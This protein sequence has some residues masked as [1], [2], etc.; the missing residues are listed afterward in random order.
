MRRRLNFKIIASVTFIILLAGA[1]LFFTLRSS[2]APSETSTNNPGRSGETIEITQARILAYWMGFDD[3]RDENNNWWTDAYYEHLNIRLTNLFTAPMWGTDFDMM[4]NLAFATGNLPDVMPLYTSLAVRAIEGGLV[5][6]LTDI[7][8][9]YAS[10]QVKE[11]FAQDPRALQAWTFDGRLMGLPQPA[12]SGDFVYFWV[13]AELL[14]QLNDGV[15]PRNFD[16]FNAL[17]RR[18]RDYTGGHAIAMD[19]NLQVMEFLMP[20]FGATSLWIEQDGALVWGR[21]QPEMQRL[22]QQ[23]A[24][25]YNEGILAVDFAAKNQEDIAYDFANRHAGLMADGSQ[26]PNGSAGRSFIM[27]HPHDDLVAIPLM[28]YDG[29]PVRIISDAGYNNALMI[30]VRAQNPEAIMHMFNLTTAIIN[31]GEYRPAWVTNHEWETSPA[32][33]M[34][35]WNALATGTGYVAD[36]QHSAAL[37]AVEAMQRGIGANE[38]YHAREFRTLGAYERINNWLQ[39][40]TAHDAW[41]ANWAMWNMTLGS[42]SLFTTGDKRAA[43]YIVPSPRWGVETLSEAT[44]NATLAMRFVEFA[45]IAIVENDVD[46]QFNHWLNFFYAN[47]GHDINREVNEWWEM[48]R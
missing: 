26:L 42:R 7:F 23:M 30:S 11:L 40:G 3:G 24:D 28:R 18:I 47:G 4:I 25:W 41:E 19:N 21:T 16:D 32:G 1:G 2:D 14:D 12:G 20:M 27:A 35:F 9:R 39:H 37:L 17:A 29:Q 44:F 36:I 46:N 31:E 8:E 45:I 22:W 48:H 5:M 13:S 43:G 38:L 15:V 10:D 33:N 6:D 34:E